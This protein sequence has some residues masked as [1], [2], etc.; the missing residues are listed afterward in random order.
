MEELLYFTI[1]WA[2]AM[3]LLLRG[4]GGISTPPPGVESAVPHEETR[5]AAAS[6]E[7]LP[8]PLH[9]VTAPWG[10]LVTSPEWGEVVVV[11][12]DHGSHHLGTLQLG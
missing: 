6:L 9:D 10:V 7:H 11:V 3:Y 2:S 12:G 1:L 4:A 8:P 5:V